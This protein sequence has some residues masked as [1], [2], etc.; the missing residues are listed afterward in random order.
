MFKKITLVFALAVAIVSAGS[1][2]LIQPSSY[3]GK[4]PTDVSIV[5]FFDTDSTTVGD[6][7]G[8]NDLLVLGP[9]KMGASDGGQFTALQLF[10]DAI[11]DSIAV[12]Y[13]T[14][15]TIYAGDTVSSGWTVFD[16]LLSTGTNQYQS[17]A[18]SAIGQ[19]L[20]LKLANV[21]ATESRIKNPLYIMLK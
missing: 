11:S 6:S 7:L 10:Q 14:T 2:T 9:I 1:S 5:K 17:I 21:N 12:S 13:Q 18:S 19:Y 4:L 20:Y 3:T 8:E 16:T 15:P